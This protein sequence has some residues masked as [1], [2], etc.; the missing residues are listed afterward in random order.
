M[1]DGYDFSASQRVNVGPGES[2]SI[3][4]F[5][6]TETP[7]VPGADA[8][9]S[10]LSLSAGELDPEFAADTEA[11]TAMVANNVTSVTV[12]GT[13]TDANASVA[14]TLEDDADDADQSNGR[15]VDLDV[16]MT[17]ITAMVV[18]EDESDTTSYVVTVTRAHAMVT[19]SAPASVEEGMPATITATVDHAQDSAFTVTV[20][21]SGGAV[22]DDDEL[23][24]AA[25]AT[26]STGT[27]TVTPTDNDERND[28]VDTVTVSATT[29]NTDVAA[30]DD[31]EIVVED[32][33]LVAT[34]PQNITVTLDET[35]DGSATVTW[36]HP[37]QGGS[38][39]I[40]SYVWET[41]AEGNV[42]KPSG[43]V[44]LST[45]PTTALS[46][47]LTG[48]ALG[49]EYTF[50]VHAVSSLG[51]GDKGTEMFEAKPGI[52]MTL[53]GTTLNEDQSDTITVTIA[54]TA[55]SEKDVTVTVAS[56][57]TDAATVA[58]ASVTIP[59]GQTAVPA[60][61]DAPT[62]VA[63][64]N[65]ED[66]NGGTDA[67]TFDVSAESDDG[68]DPADQTVTITDDDTLSEAPR[69]L[70]VTAGNTQLTL[71]WISPANS[72]NSD[73]MHYQYR[74]SDETLDDDDEWMTVDDGAN[75]RRAVI[76]GLENGTT[77]NIEVRAV[78]AAGN[79]AAATGSG[80]PASSE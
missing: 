68:R 73:V 33:E 58:N 18:S 28:P 14:I 6:A 56:D 55:A 40:T 77:Y 43:T 61:V 72:G 57:D 23:M 54:L 52:T 37:A 53:S 42:A 35:T 41:S 3:D 67:V 8:T 9:L 24:F 25:G 17:A 11:Y 12:T 78:T 46:A 5:T 65:D 2:K 30:I 75:A 29:T 79:G 31:V 63:V 22:S 51:N 80:A 20:T 27:V 49:I 48:L 36:E 70:T 62:I 44:D 71:E 13:A 21:A 34:V 15:S 26:A 1:K 66:D 64:Q 32:D 47:A 69:N 16:G 45:D 74:Y 4:D 7:R 19:L 10:A 39:P 50:S 60:T 76:T 59:A 38:A